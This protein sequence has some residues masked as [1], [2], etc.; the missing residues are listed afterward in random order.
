MSRKLRTVN[1]S[2]PTT[3]SLLTRLTHVAVVA[4]LATAGAAA[5][6]NAPVLSL[7]QSIELPSVSGRLD[8]L[9]IDA[10]SAQLFVV[11]LVANSVEVVL[12][13]GKRVARLRG[14][15]E[16]QGAVYL[17]ESRRLLVANG[18]GGGVT[19]FVD[20]KPLPVASAGELDDADN[21]RFDA[22]EGLLY[23]GYGHSLAIVDPA[24]MRIRKRI[25][26]AGH[27][28]AFELERAGR[29]IYV[30]VQSL[31]ADRVELMALGIKEQIIGVDSSPASARRR[32]LRVGANRA[33]LARRTH[34]AVRG[35]AVD[36]LRGGSIGW[37]RRGRSPGL[38]G[39]VALVNAAPQASQTSH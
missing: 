34:R 4:S 29:R 14:I 23:A 8:H 11:A 15:H 38:H 7:S 13:A 31:P 25:E 33:H 1:R 5:A 21:L 6:A 10:E 30:N 27:P 18:S 37:R 3:T 17:P 24:T 19:A 20:G 2:R 36:D 16:P 26:L 35:R 32:P 39:Q 9:A 12:R 28:E 22:A